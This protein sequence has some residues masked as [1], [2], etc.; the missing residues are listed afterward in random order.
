MLKTFCTKRHNPIEGAIYEMDNFAQ[1]FNKYRNRSSK[2]RLGR[3][4]NNILIEMEFKK[5]ET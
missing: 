5:L 1:T 2:T 3:Y 4:L